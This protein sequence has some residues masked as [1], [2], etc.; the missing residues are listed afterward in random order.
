LRWSDRKEDFRTEVLGLVKAQQVKNAVIVPVGSKGGFY[1]K[2]LPANGSREEVQQAA[3]AAYKTYLCGLL[4]ITDNLVKGEVVTPPQVIRHDGDDPYLVVA[5]DKGT[6]TFSD[7]ANGIA[8]DYGFWLDDAFASGGSAGYDHKKMGITA[9]GGWVSVQ[10]HF[11]E[12]GIDTQSEDFTVVGIGDMAGDVFGNGMLLSRHIRLV[13]A[14]N[15]LHIFL[16]PN[17]DAAASFE[18]R[19]R[20]FHLPRSSWK[21]YNPALISQGGGVFE[22]SAKTI[23]LSPEVRQR[24]GV[25]AEQMTPDELIRTLLKAPVDLLWNGGIGTYVKAVT[26]THEQVGDRANNA[27]RVNGRDLRCKVVGEGGNL[28]FTQSGRIEYALTGGRLNTDAIDN[29]AGVDCS[30]HEVNIKIALQA[31]VAKQRLDTEARNRLLESMTDRVAELVLR[32]NFLQTQILSMMQQQ[33]ADALDAQQRLMLA[34]EKDGLLNREIEYLPGDEEIV[35]RKDSRQPLTRPELA[36]LLA[37]SKLKLY[38]ELL[39]CNLPDDP[40]LVQE[41]HEYFPEALVKTYREEL[42]SHALRREI[43][44]TSVTNSIINRMGATFFNDMAEQTGASSAAV[45]RAFL[46]TREVFGLKELW[47]RIENMEGSITA[48]AQGQLALAI[49]LFA[50]R[51]TVWLL[52]NRALTLPL[53]EEIQRLAPVVA[54]YTEKCLSLLAESSRQRYENRLNLHLAAD[55]PEEMAETIARLGALASAYDIAVVAELTG[56]KV[57]TIGKV[58]FAAGEALELGWLRERAQ[59]LPAGSAWDRQAVTLLVSAFYHEQRRL[60]VEVL[61]TPS[62]DFSAPKEAFLLWQNQE[63]APER[64][65]AIAQVNRMLKDFHN[66]PQ[67]SFPMLLLAQRAIEAVR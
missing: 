62:V 64:K 46:V 14:F 48:E 67:L 65:E 55:V 1:P 16:D 18:E 51:M 15:H 24:L 60:T 33:G 10:R 42:E 19:E 17:P 43:I 45:A 52:R 61:K 59:L 22:R 56:Q 53:G 49:R 37:Y 41:L 25:T 36:V 57:E 40:Y 29:S 47:H 63:S 66:L 4:D 3:I 35:R 23:P 58:Y 6:A 21:D 32:D 50:E 5:A 54:E 39:A 27:L 11:R 7:I 8:R 26:E 34:L 2:N 12:M 30:D 9:K 20:L 38:P 13:G 44:A 28:G 31:A